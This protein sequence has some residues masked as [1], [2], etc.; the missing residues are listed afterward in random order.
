MRRSCILEAAIAVLLIA[1]TGIAARAQ[2]PPTPIRLIDLQGHPVAGAIVGTDLQHD[3]DREPSFTSREGIEARTDERGEASLAIRYETGIYAIREDHDRPLVGVTTV[4]REQLGKPAT[5]V[6]HPACRVRLRV[7]CPG[8]R[9]LEEKYHAELGGPTWERMVVVQQGD[10]GRVPRLLVTTSRT[11]EL[12]VLLPPGRYTIRAVGNEI[13]SVSRSVEI[14]PGHRVRSLGIIGVRPSG[15]VKQ[16]IFPDFWRWNQQSPQDP[17][18][19]EGIE[20]RVVYHRREWGPAPRDA[21]GIQRLAF[22]PDGK[23]LATS[24]GYNDR[25]GQ[26]KLW[27][28]RTGTL[29]AT[30]TGPEG[31][32]GVHELAFSP[33]GAILAGSVASMHNFQLPSSVILWDVA[34]RRVTRTLRGHTATITALAFSPDG[35]T[36]ASG[37]GDATVRFWDVASGRE[38]GRLKVDIEW[39]RAIVYAPDGQTLAVAYGEALKLWDMAGRHFRATLEPGG[40]WVH[41]VAFAPDGRTLA[42]SGM[43]VQP[44]NQVRDGQVRLYDMIS[45]PHRRRA[46]L[47]LDPG[48]PPWVNA[49]KDSFGDVVFTPNGRRVISNRVGTIVMWDAASGVELA[50]LARNNG[51]SSDDLA[52][53]LDGRWLA[54]GG[55]HGAYV[56]MIAIPQLPAP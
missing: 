8:F 55:K 11:G 41:S 33:D 18:A 42:A 43:I 15:N 36:L 38:A 21:N 19:S 29:T 13:Q 56:S 34:G 16:G 52:V 22:S 5:I 1:S 3:R 7:E 26:V 54:V 10:G 25:P 40:F 20:R 39:P 23:V 30:L 50:S 31:E 44:N 17:P 47:I 2:A 37:G 12:E 28:A 6:M 49:G 4:T 14:Q 27:D 32:D 24:H 45:R 53:S 51:V 35:R 9:E 48:G 46:T